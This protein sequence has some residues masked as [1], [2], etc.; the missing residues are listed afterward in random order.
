MRDTITL[1]LPQAMTRQIEDACR[2]E[3]RTKSELM[4]EAL[5]VYFG[6]ARSLPSYTLTRA[7]L[8]GI[9]K[10]REEIRRGDYY[11]LDELHASLEG[12]DR[13]PRAKESRPHAGPR[14][15]AA[16]AR[17]RRIPSRAELR[18]SMPRLRVP[19][20]VLIRQDRELR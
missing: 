16:A 15:G 20:E 17:H 12:H 3:H 9:R 7:E 19:S 8:E 14:A 10:G 11:T 2:R 5:R 18:A 4:R 13:R 6:T 1:S